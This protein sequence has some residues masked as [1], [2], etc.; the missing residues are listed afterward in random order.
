MFDRVAPPGGQLFRALVLRPCGV[1][2]RDAERQIG[3]AATA[4]RDERLGV[5]DRLCRQKRDARIR[6]AMNELPPVAFTG[7]DAGHP[8][9]EVTHLGAA[10]DLGLAAL[11]ENSICE[12]GSDDLADCVNGGRLAVAKTRRAAIQLLDDAGPSSAERTEGVAEGY[13]VASRV[14]RLVAVGIASQHLVE[15]FPRVFNCLFEPVRCHLPLPPIAPT[16]HR[17][18]QILHPNRPG[19][20]STQSGKLYRTSAVLDVSLPSDAYCPVQSAPVRNERAQNSGPGGSSDYRAA[21]A[22]NAETM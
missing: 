13:V 3:R 11:N 16:E 17:A 21:P 15:R 1:R 4:R 22:T 19:S 9:R 8:D 5:E 12:V 10:T 14:Q 6:V 20:Q 7:V 18:V 2:D